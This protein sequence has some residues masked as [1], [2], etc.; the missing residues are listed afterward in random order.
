M[1]G[2]HVYN[3]LDL[4]FSKM[5][6]LA[7][8]LVVSLLSCVSLSAQWFNYPAKGIPRTTDGKPNLSAAGAQKHRTARLIFQESGWQRILDKFLDLSLGVDGGAIP[9]RPEIMKLVQGSARSSS[10]ARVGEPSG[11][12]SAERPCDATHVGRR[13][14]ENYPDSWTAVTLIEYNISITKSFW[15]GGPAR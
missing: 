2:K 4:S 11:Q 6:R 14:E 3:P 12:L 7:S 10:V 9:Y 5:D 8:V 15:T 1:L 13:S